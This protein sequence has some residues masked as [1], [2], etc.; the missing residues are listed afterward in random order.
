[1]K[2]LKRYLRFFMAGCIFSPT[3]LFAVEE[4][5]VTNVTVNGTI[6]ESPNC[7][8]NNNNPVDVDFGDDI[9]VNKINGYD[10][11]RQTIVYRIVC[12]TASAVPLKVA[13]TGADPGFGDG[14]ISTSKDGLGI[15]LFNG[16]DK[17]STGEYVSFSYTNGSAV[18]ELSAALIT[19]DSLSVSTGGFTGSGVLLVDY[20]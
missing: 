7:I 15:Q 4:G 11:K 9:I 1:M 2:L 3:A 20:Q 13:V 19:R 18:P 14:L 5:D 16:N 17:I 10:Y 6:V 12:D 8:L